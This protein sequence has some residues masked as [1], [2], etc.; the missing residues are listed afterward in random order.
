MLL[1]VSSS[2]MAQKDQGKAAIEKRINAQR[3]AYITNELDLQENEAE[4]FWPMYKQFRK[5]MKTVRK[6]FRKE[7]NIDEMTNEEA[8]AFLEKTLA[9]DEEEIAIKRK[10]NVLF[11][12]VLPVKKV[13]KLHIA[14]RSF[15]KEMLKKIK[16]RR[17]NGNGPRGGNR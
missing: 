12:T 11:K 9:R 3:V 2:L 1:T 7:R 8:E 6:E 16:E 10:Y 4:K 17:G 5:E 15:K 14:E 13:V